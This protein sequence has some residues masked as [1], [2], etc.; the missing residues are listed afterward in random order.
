MES[1]EWKNMLALVAPLV[2]VSED[3]LE[4]RTE[5]EALV[6]G[7]SI[8]V[9]TKIGRT[10]IAGIVTDVTNGVVTIRSEQDRIRSFPSELYNFLKVTTTEDKNGLEEINIGRQG[11]IVAPVPDA[12]PIDAGI[13]PQP[14]DLFKMGPLPITH[15]G[16]SDDTRESIKIVSK[17]IAGDRRWANE[18]WMDLT[19]MGVARTMRKHSIGA[20]SMANIVAELKLAKL[21]AE[22]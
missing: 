18:V 20:D 17:Y 1:L 5:A 8:V 21:Y 2:P 19:T 9:T 6:P 15:P 22:E 10:M 11:T 7:D 4:I 12:P 3:K 14:P 13:N 16:T